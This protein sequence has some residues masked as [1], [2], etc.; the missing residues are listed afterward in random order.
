MQHLF[1]PPEAVSALSK[2][3]GPSETR[4]ILPLPHA[5]NCGKTR[6]VVSGV[7]VQVICNNR[8]IL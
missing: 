5:R 8:L 1:N 4:S 7:D 2:N 3:F 6:K